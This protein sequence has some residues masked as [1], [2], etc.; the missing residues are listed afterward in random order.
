MA[1]CFSSSRESREARCERACISVLEL[2]KNNHN[3]WDTAG[4]PLVGGETV[5]AELG[6]DQPHPSFRWTNSV[7]FSARHQLCTWVLSKHPAAVRRSPQTPTADAATATAGQPQSKSLKRVDRFQN[8]IHSFS[9]A[10]DFLDRNGRRRRPG[11]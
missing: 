8:E 2:G 5:Q 11:G 1:I 4:F 6:A 3:E 7:P 10:V 9:A